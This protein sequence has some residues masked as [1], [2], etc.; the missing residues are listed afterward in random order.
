MATKKSGASKKSGAARKSAAPKKA[1]AARKAGSKK[2]GAQKAGARKAGAKKAGSKRAGAVMPAAA[3]AAAAAPE[4]L[5]R[6]SRGPE[7]EKLQEELCDLGYMTR[8]QMVQGPGRFGP[9]TEDALK[10]FQRDNFIPETGVNDGPTQAAIRQLNEGVRRGTEGDVVRGLQNRLV[11]L[12]FMTMAQTVTGLGRFGPLTENALI[13]FQQA[14]GIMAN[15]V[16]TDETYRSLLASAPAPM[17]RPVRATRRASRRCSPQRASGL[18]PTGAS[19]AAPTRWAAPRPS[20]A[21]WRWPRPGAS[22]TPRRA[23]R[24]ATS[25]G[26]AAAPSRRTAA[27]ASAWTWTCGPS[28][29]T[30]ARSRPTS[31]SPATRAR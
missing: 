5:R 20:A 30:A 4:F 18:R 29:T 28:P 31:A 1:G 8:A 16:L 11:S 6:G 19:L 26:A 15:G 25:A 22:A 21:S 7:V 2:A 12:G 14:H 3:L 13:A 17:P 24:S 27:T 23:S 10:H 9:L